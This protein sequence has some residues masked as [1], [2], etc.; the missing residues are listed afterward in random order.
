MASESH[1]RIR[2]HERINIQNMDSNLAKNNDK[3]SLCGMS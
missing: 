1:G 2:C 3:Q